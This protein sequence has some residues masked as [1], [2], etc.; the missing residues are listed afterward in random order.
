[1][2]FDLF[3]GFDSNVE[4]QAACIMQENGEVGD[5]IDQ[6]LS[7]SMSDSLPGANVD[8]TLNGLSDTMEP[9]SGMVTPLV[10]E[11]G[12]SLLDPEIDADQNGIPDAMEISDGMVASLVDENGNS[13]LD[14][15]IDA[16]QNG[17]PDAM[18]VSGGM[19][20]PFVDENGRS[21]LDPEIDANQNGIPDAMENPDVQGSI[22][23]PVFNFFDEIM[24]GFI[25]LFSDNP[26]DL[27][28][29][30]DFTE[31]GK[32]D[33]KN[34]LIVV[35]NVEHDLHF[36]DQ[37]THGS[38]SLMAQEQFVHRYIGQSIPE[39]YLEWR[40]AKWGVY[41]PDCGTDVNG[42]TKVLEHFNIP[43]QRFTGDLDDIDKALSEHK[44]IIIGVDAREFY[45]DASIPAG[46]GHAVAIVG[47]GLDPDSHEI[48]G[49]YITDSNHP[50]AVHLVE[51]DRLSSSWNHDLITVP[52][53]EFAIA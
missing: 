33:K 50:N 35:G 25:S 9:S 42:Q 39:D 48:S 11:N 29:S 32:F 7:D 30:K 12:N 43:H 44:D 23:T 49:Y 2:L 19:V 21:L 53:K 26:N 27:V 28:T 16:D 31:D 47:A 10:D 17:I 41:S 45:Q 13:L 20:T 4:P 36:V 22:L 1:M 38:C 6:P 34:N 14:L 3:E 40:A 24:D 8:A 46:S 5:S 51:V 18:E 15:E 37:Q 52:E